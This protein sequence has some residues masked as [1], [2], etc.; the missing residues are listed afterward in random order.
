MCWGNVG[1][2]AWTCSRPA[3]RSTRRRAVRPIARR[4]PS[5]GTSMA[6]AMVA[7]AA[8]LAEGSSPTRVRRHRSGRADAAAR[9]RVDCRLGRPISVAGGR[10][11]AAR[12]VDAAR[13]PLGG[14]DEPA[15]LDVVRPRPRRGPR[16]R[17]QV[18]GRSPARGAHRRLP[19]RRRRRRR[20]ERPTTARSVA[21]ADQADA[22]GDGMGN[23]CDQTPRG[24]DAD[25]DGKPS[26]D[27]RCP[28]VAARSPTAARI[29]VDPPRP[30]ATPTPDADR[31][32]PP[33][34]PD[35]GRR[36]ARAS[37]SPKCPKAQDV[38]EGGQGHGEADA[39]GDGSLRFD[40]SSAGAGRSGSAGRLGRGRRDERAAT[41][42]RLKTGPTA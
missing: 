5:S 4:L 41:L 30:T 9:R 18:P 38:H 2:A 10:L 31:R 3:S 32:R 1:R 20:D 29:V 17:R 42:K 28:T 37:R 26:L 25:G 16:R 34:T 15:G 14:A 21:N 36:V 39:H 40:R 12:A 7:G 24:D 22:D 33:P 35:A 27:D 13:Q 6:A 23:A 8:A 19:G 11:N